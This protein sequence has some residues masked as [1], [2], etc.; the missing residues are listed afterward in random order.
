MQSSSNE[1]GR[2]VLPQMFDKGIMPDNATYNS[3]LHGYCSLGQCKEALRIFRKMCRDG[4]GPNVVTYNSLMDFLCK[5]G[6]CAEARK[7]FYSMVEMTKNPMLLPMAFC[8]MATLPKVPLLI[9][10]IF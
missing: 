7:I 5:N 1:Q 8:F 4:L 3:L 6:R 2:G 9:C 10:M